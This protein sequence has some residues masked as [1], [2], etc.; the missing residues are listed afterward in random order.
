MWLLLRRLHLQ[1]LRRWRLRRRRLRRR[2]LRRRRRRQPLLVLPRLAPSSTWPRCASLPSPWPPCCDGLLRSGA[3][4]AAHRAG[5]TSPA[6]P[7]V[8][9]LAPSASPR[10]PPLPCACSPTL[11]LSA[12]SQPLRRA[13]LARVPLAPLAHVVHKRSH[14]WLVHRPLRVGPREETNICVSFPTPFPKREEYTRE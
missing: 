13:S 6:V 1:L 7:Q 14:H 9:A 8:V 2:R 3:G 12:S 5:D 10:K 4:P 11:L